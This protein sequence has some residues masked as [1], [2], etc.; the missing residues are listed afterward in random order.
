MEQ[1]VYLTKIDELAKTN[2][3]FSRVY[4]GNEFC[5]RLLPKLEDLKEILRFVSRMKFT[6]VT[7]Y[8]TNKGLRNLEELF[9]YTA[10]ASPGCEVVFNDYGVLRT[11]LNRYSAKLKPV[12]GRLLNKMKRGPRL[13]NLIDILPEPTIKYFKGTS[14]DTKVIR[15]FLL[16]NKIKR[17]EL[18]N[19]LQGIEL[20]LAKHGITASLYIPYAYITTTRA[21]LAINC[22]VHGKEDEVGIFPCKKECQKYVFHLRSTAMPVALIRKGNTVFLKNDK[23]PP[24]LENIGVDRIVHEPNIPL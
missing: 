3:Q 23:I 17:V 20:N 1:A 5:E 9:D 12:M 24:N 18:D 8:V 11:L 13:M 10:N 19:L 2:V 21:C 7:P 16:K 6:F 22:D 15:D 14:L 4:F